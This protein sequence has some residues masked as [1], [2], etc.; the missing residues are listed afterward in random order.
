MIICLLPSRPDRKWS[1]CG[2]QL[3]RHAQA[4]KVVSRAVLNGLHREYRLVPA[5]A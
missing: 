1:F 2:A 4:N 5:V 3:I